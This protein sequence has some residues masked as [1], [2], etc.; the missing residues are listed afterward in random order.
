ML[1]ENHPLLG[2]RFPLA[3]ACRSIGEDCHRTI[4]LHSNEMSV[5][6]LGVGLFHRVSNSVVVRLGDIAERIRSMRV[7]AKRVVY[8]IRTDVVWIPNGQLISTCIIRYGRHFLQLVN[9]TERVLTTDLTDN[10][11]KLHQYRRLAKNTN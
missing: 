5:F 11:A 4:Y 8:H 7:S 1:V 3:I 9:R 6:V 2:L 10:D